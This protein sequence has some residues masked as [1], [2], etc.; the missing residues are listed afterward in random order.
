MPTA[1]PVA[2][3]KEPTR[4]P[5]SKKPIQKKLAVGAAGD[6]FEREA[7]RV[8]HRA[9]RGTGG[10]VSI[11]PSIS[12]LG[13]QRA[14]LPSPVK[15]RAKHEAEPRKGV[16]TPQR[17]PAA[18]VPRIEADK[19]SGQRAQRRAS[20]DDGGGAA[21]VS[22]ESSISRMQAGGGRALDAGARNLMESR[23]GHDFGGVRV[24]QG[25]DAT[26]AAQALNARA[27]TVGHDV[28][29]N[30]GEYRPQTPSGREL[31]AHELTHT[32]QQGGGA[33]RKRVQRTTP[34][35]TGT[36]TTPLQ[37]PV[38]APTV[39]AGDPAQV[40][41]TATFRSPSLPGAS[42]D[43]TPGERG[44][45][46]TVTLPILGLPRI[47]GQLKGTPGALM[48]PVASEG[49][50]VPR[51]GEAFDLR[52]LRATR[53]PRTFEIWN[54]YARGQRFKDGLT[55]KLS[56]MVRGSP[57][58]A[59]LRGSTRDSPAYALKLKRR[60]D[61][62]FVGTIDQLSANEALVRPQWSPRGVMAM[63]PVDG[64]DADHFLEFQLGGLDGGENLWLLDASYNRSVGPSITRRIETQLGT[65]ITEVNASDVRLPRKPVDVNEIKRDWVIHFQTVADGGFTQTARYFWRPA[66]ILAGNHLDQLAVMTGPD[67]GTVSLNLESSGAQPTEILVFPSRGGGR[68]QRFRIGRDNRVMAGGRLWD[69]D[70][71]VRGGQ[72]YPGVTD[73]ADATLLTLDVEA[74]TRRDGARIARKSVEGITFK[75]LP[76]FGL[77]GYLTRESLLAKLRTVDFEPMSPLTF[78][79]LG[80]DANGTLY[81]TGGVLSSKALFPAPYCSTVTVRRPDY[82]EFSDPDREP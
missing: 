78:S 15:K 70:F 23:L 77:A 47:E 3:Q 43:A 29:F 36:G 32:V 51:E 55:A 16:P 60:R 80:L 75:R 26:E 45:K 69:N 4:K 74:F 24:H 19:R 68:I 35:G 33:A 49:H 12:S 46:G 7:D 21:P 61:Y 10:A 13:A 54:A 25:P 39:A 59:Q 76:E 66:Q 30:A 64:L 58:A 17:K 31:I 52:P 42:I 6:R 28:F 79:D 8:A 44:I 56:A 5:A 2:K 82:D 67:L 9:V 81:G 41:P 53:L 18:S 72:Y 14:P 50:E 22:V 40:I 27:F 20:G 71:E 37:E 62:V 57:N 34:P 1:K 48:T 73:Q 63:S 11:P 65:V 38:A